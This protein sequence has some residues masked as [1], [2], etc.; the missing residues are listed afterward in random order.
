[1]ERLYLEDPRNENKNK[2]IDLVN[3]Y[4]NAQKHMTGARK[5]QDFFREKNYEGWLAAV[6]NASEGLG[7]KNPSKLYFVKGESDD[8]I[9]GTLT[10]KYVGDDIG[11]NVEYSIRPTEEKK[12]YEK[13]I[14]RLALEEL[15]RFGFNEVRIDEIIGKTRSNNAIKAAGG[16]I[17]SQDHVLRRYSIDLDNSSDRVNAEVEDVQTK[18]K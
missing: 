12:G 11:G 8:R 4:N 10:L 2:V 18:V 9:I 14:I 6:S 3:E 15:K 1:M 7:V 13:E 17:V 16:K 5:I